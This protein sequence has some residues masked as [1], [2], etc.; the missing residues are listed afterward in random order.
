M[1]MMHTRRDLITF[2]LITFF[3]AMEMNFAI[4]AS[5][6]WATGRVTVEKRNPINLYL[7]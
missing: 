7:M 3:P 2:L 1:M 5:S 4:L 6:P